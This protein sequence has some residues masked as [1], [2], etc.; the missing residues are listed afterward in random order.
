M[1]TVPVSGPK[2][3]SHLQQHL[4]DAFGLSFC[5]PAYTFKKKKPDP[6]AS[7]NVSVVSQYSAKVIA[8]EWLLGREICPAFFLLRASLVLHTQFL[9]GSFV[10]LAWDLLF[11]TL[12]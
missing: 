2:P 9:E 1:K 10:S 5:S 6:F 7:Q 8:Y 11:F 3:L 4:K 12:L